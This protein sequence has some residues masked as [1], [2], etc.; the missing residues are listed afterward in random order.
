MNVIRWYNDTDR[1]WNLDAMESKWYAV[2]DSEGK[3]H[4]A[5][6][7]SED[8]RAISILTLNAALDEE[9]R[10]EVP[11]IL[12][13]TKE[14]TGSSRL[15]GIAFYENT[16]MRPINPQELTEPLTLE[17]ALMA[18]FMRNTRFYLPV[19]ESPVVVSAENADSISLD[20]VDISEIPDIRDSDGDGE[21]INSTFAVRDIY[22]AEFDIT[23]KV[24]GAEDTLVHIEM[25]EVQPAVYTGEKLAPVLV[26]NGETL[27]EGT[28]Y[29]WEPL[30]VP[31][32]EE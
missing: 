4:A 21:V 24:A 30:D 11:V 9:K 7:F 23:D 17:P 20:Y 6:I 25:A 31:E 5:A 10:R 16:G 2:N 26:Y 1:T 13:F 8:D 27:T 18:T 28:D 15:S 22:G 32:E 3:L 29:T 19:S 12:T 14:E